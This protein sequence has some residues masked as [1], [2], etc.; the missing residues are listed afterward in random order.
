[1]NATTPKD[2]GEAFRAHGAN[3]FGNHFRN[4]QRP[5]D[6]AGSPKKEKRELPPIKSARKLV[7][8]NL[9]PPA[10]VVHGLLHQGSKM[11][12]GGGSKSFKTWCLADLA[13][14]I[15]NGVPWWGVNTNKGRVLYMNYEIQEGFF[16]KRLE[17]I[18]MAKGLGA[19]ALDDVDTWNLRGFCAD[20]SDLIASLL[21]QIKKDHYVLIVVDPI[22]KVLGGRDENSAGE[23]GK[24]LNEVER[25]AVETGAAVVF[26]AHFSKGNQAGRESIDRI[27]GSG[28]FARDPDTILTMTKHDNEFTYTVDSTLRNF[29]QMDSFCVKWVYPLMA[30]DETADPANLKQAG[31]KIEK[32]TAQQLFVVLNVQK[33]ATTEWE[34]QSCEK[35]GM[36]SRTFAVKKKELV[37][38]GRVKQVD[39]DKWQAVDPVYP[40]GWN[41]EREKEK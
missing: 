18:A 3:G 40:P 13:V 15:A 24:L 21:E 33:L 8:Q 39:G 35:T 28:V 7:D 22:Y 32:F 16:A 26:G 5:F 36:K 30:R 4:N 17:S 20:L 25:L 41:S 19:E 31:A 23:I 6:P 27:S 14:S 10:V 38:A 34:K 11:V 37:D 2:A 1:M 9:A 29:A 12:L